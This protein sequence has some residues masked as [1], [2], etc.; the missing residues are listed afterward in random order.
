MQTLLELFIIFLVNTLFRLPFIATSD[1]DEWATFYRI[2]MQG[3]KKY[4]VYALQD[5]IIEGYLGAPRLQYFIISL[6][7][8]KHWSYVGNGLNIFYDYLT[9]L[10]I[11]GLVYFTL[12]FG[13]SQVFYFSVSFWASILFVTSPIL[14]SITPR[15][16]GVKARTLGLFLVVTYFV[17]LQF[18]MLHN[19]YWLIPVLLVIGILCI[20]S[21]AFSMQNLIFLSVGLSIYLL[22]WRPV[23]LML[24]TFA[25]GYILPKWGVKPVLLHKANHYLWYSRNRKGTTAQGKNSLKDV[26]LMPHYLVK[27]QRKFFNL[28]LREN[29]YLILLYSVPI[30][31]LCF[32]ILTSTNFNLAVYQQQTNY[33]FYIGLILSG[34][35]AFIL[36]SLRPFLLFGEAERYF[37]YIIG[38]ISILFVNICLRVESEGLILLG[39]LLNLIIIQLFLIFRFKGFIRRGSKPLYK[40]SNLD[41]CI[42]FLSKFES[43]PRVLTIPLKYSYYLGYHTRGI[44]YYQ[45]FVTSGNNINGFK[46]MT[47]D[48]AMYDY[49]KDDINYFVNKYNINLV[50]VSKN[51]YIEKMFKYDFESWRMDIV[52]ENE[53]FLIFERTANFI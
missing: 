40:D 45:F 16:T 12:G 34:V 25:F 50:V 33:N 6:F 1:S 8:E 20:S 52:F 19:V 44:K 51:H 13:G 39:V 24:A 4:P 11:Y 41:E 10:L 9:G 7:K 35:G 38:F 31:W 47:E 30:I 37:E 21:S 26:F 49:P 48:L 28:F 17:L 22:D 42:S 2:K 53:N 5:S 36:T 18:V 3:G 46:Y 27:N 32:Y 15:L 29:S 23:I 14:F 43:K